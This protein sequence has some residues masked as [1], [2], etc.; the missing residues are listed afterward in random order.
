[1]NVRAWLE[2]LPVRR[3]AKFGIVGASG[4]VVNV[5]ML[6]LLQERLLSFIADPQARLNA[7]VPA[8]IACATVNNF[9]WNRQW[10]WSDREVAT[11]GGVL[12]QFAQYAGACWLGS[13]IQF[14][15]T[16]LLAW[17]WHYLVAN[18]CAIGVASLFNFVLNDRWTF[19]RW[20]PRASGT[21]R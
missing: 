21:A 2:R 18:V 9:A 19:A 3:F 17:H 10:T 6:W 13:T 14:V 4:I 20:R 5:A 11:R 7:S 16:K 8:A 15:V 12:V 1:M